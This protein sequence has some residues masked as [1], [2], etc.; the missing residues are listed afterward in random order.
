L[1]I[2]TLQPELHLVGLLY[3]IKKGR[4]DHNCSVIRL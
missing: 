3:I 2:N 1:L 4:L